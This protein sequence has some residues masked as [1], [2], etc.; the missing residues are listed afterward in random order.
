MLDKKFIV[1]LEDI[2]VYS[3]T[4][5]D[6][7]PDSEEVFRCLQ[8]NILITKGSKCEFLQ[9]E[10]E[11]LGHVVSGEGI[12]IDPRKLTAISQWKPPTNI[13]ELQS[14]LGF[15][16]YVRR[17]V[18]NMAGVTKPLTDLLHKSVLFLWGEREQL[19]FDKL[20]RIWSSPS[21]LRPANPS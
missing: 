17:F 12:K 11:F 21:V 15:M 4:R 16:N 10:L 19:A 2:L 13:T 9:P 6:H 5:E 8:Q 14:F 3:T 1:Y 7:L 20:K 18:P